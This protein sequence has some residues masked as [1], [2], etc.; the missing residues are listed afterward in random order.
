MKSEHQIAAA[1]ARAHHTV[2]D[3]LL[4]VRDTAKDEI[5]TAVRAGKIDVSGLPT[6][7]E[8]QVEALWLNAERAADATTKKIRKP[9]KGVQGAL[10][11]GDDYDQMVVVCRGRRTTLGLLTAEDRRLMAEESHDNRVKI[12]KA[13]DDEQT[14]AAVEIRLL[15][16]FADYRSYD[17]HRRSM[18]G[19]A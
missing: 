2:R 9:K 17:R 8:F 3:N 7:E 4:L 11:Y 5:R 12:D 10:D 6:L 18:G 13:D 1:A 14:T 15:Q 16:P 19:A